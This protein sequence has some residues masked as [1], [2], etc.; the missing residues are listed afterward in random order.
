MDGLHFVTGTRRLFPFLYSI[1]GKYLIIQGLLIRDFPTH[2]ADL[3][4]RIQ[5]VEMFQNITLNV[6][7][8]S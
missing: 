7:R 1:S 6:E 3:Y 4:S 5:L 8:I 2:I